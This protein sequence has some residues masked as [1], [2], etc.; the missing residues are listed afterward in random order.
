MISL[1]DTNTQQAKK[2]NRRF[3]LL[4][5]LSLLVAGVLFFNPVMQAVDS[6]ISRFTVEDYVG[7]GEGTV[8]IVI[9]EGDLGEDVAR[10]L[11]AAD[12]VKS[13]D[14]IY[15]P[16]LGTD[17]V[18]FPGHYEF[19]LQISGAEALKILLESS[20][21]TNAVTIPEGF[22]VAQIVPL[23][24]ENLG[25]PESELFAAI[26][27]A[28]ESYP[29]P[30]LEGYLFPAT[31]Q[32]EPDST[33]SEVIAAM[34]S[35]MEQELNKFEVS[36]DQSLSV[37]TL[38]S[39][40]QEEARLREDFYKV[41]TVFNNRLEK[42]MLLQT[43]PTVKYYYEGSIT[44]FQQGIADTKNPY[45]T[46]VYTGLP[47]GPISSPGSLAIEAALNPAPGEYLFFVT[48]NLDSGETIFSETLREHEKAVELYR[49]WLRE[50]PDWDE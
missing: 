41:S 47:P 36:F 34:L 23:L 12:V 46:Y 48:I 5:V 18:I 45:N 38:A 13:F 16:M 28:N 27:A 7:R 11:V 32:F 39:I 8:V 30:T 10:K 35:R 25:I 19:P 40:I 43:D 9:E 20:P 26:D 44:S 14:A 3:A 4:I 31:Y 21:I 15:R 42:G 24:S 50:N 29:G 37:L 49:K 2:P 6:V 1:Q 17:L 22:Q 33:A